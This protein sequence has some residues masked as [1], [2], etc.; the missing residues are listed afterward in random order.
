[1]VDGKQLALRDAVE[2]LGDWHPLAE[3][4]GA[5]DGLVT[6]GAVTAMLSLPAVHNLGSF[7]EFMRGYRERVL[8]PFELP[9]ILA[10]HG[11]AAAN[12]LRELVA[13]DERLAAE[14]VLQLFAEPSRR[15]GRHQLRKL[16]PLRDQRFVRRFLEAMEAEKAQAWHMLVYGVTLWV[17][18]LPLRQGLLGYAHQTTRGFIYAAAG[19]LRWSE[20]T[21]RTL[22]DEL[23]ADLPQAVE[24]LVAPLQPG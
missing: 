22:F 11:H 16:R 24:Q 21:C 2:W 20:H 4:L 15:V 7:R 23:C 19:M 10:A 9:S 1:M 13:L 6:M 8:I 5:A 17:Y 18:S 3:Q 14:P 12:E